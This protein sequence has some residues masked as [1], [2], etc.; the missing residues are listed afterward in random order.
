MLPVRRR[1]TRPALKGATGRGDTGVHHFDLRAGD[2]VDS[3]FCG[4]IEDVDRWPL[5]R[6]C[7][8]VDPVG[9]HQ[10]ASLNV[11]AGMG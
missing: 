10:A 7:Q 11:G 2:G 9:L 5:A 1:H 8:V 4:R 6:H 3:F